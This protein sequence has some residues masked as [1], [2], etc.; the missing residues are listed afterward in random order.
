LVLTLLLSLSLVACFG[1]HGGGGGG[2]NGGGGGGNG[3][4]G[5]G[6][7]G[8]GGGGGGGATVTIVEPTVSG[9]QVVASSTLDFV[10]KVKGGSG[11]GVNWGVQSGDTCTNSNGVSSLGTLGGNNNIGTIPTTTANQAVAVYNAPNASAIPGSGFLTVTVTALQ[12]PSTMGPC[13]VV[14]VLPTTNSLIFGNY[15]FRLKG[16]SNSSGLPF[17]IVGRLH[18]DGVGKPDLS[19]GI[20]AGLEDVNIAQAN[21]SSAAFTKVAFT[22]GYDMDSPSHGTMKLTIAT[23][24]A[25]WAALPNP[26]PTTMN[27]SFTLSLDGFFGGLIETDGSLSPVA[28]V[29]SGDFQ[30]QANSSKFTTANI[31]NFYTMSLAG[32]AGVG[33]SA[34]NKG[35]IGRVQLTATSLSAGT[36]VSGVNSTGD[37]QSGT[38]LQTGPQMLTGTYLIDDQTN[39]HGTLTITATLNAKN[40][41]YTISFYIGFPRFFYALR[42]DDNPSGTPDGILLGT[43]N[44]L[45]ATSPFTNT[46]LGSAQFEMLG[47]TSS[48]HGSAAAGVLVGGAGQNSTTQGLLQG[49]VDFNDG[50]SLPASPPASFISTAPNQSSFTIAPTGRGT[51]S[52]WV[53]TSNGP[54]AF[55]FVFYLN[56]QGGGYLLEQPASDGSNRGRSGSFFP[57]T[58][59]SG[60]IG[61]FVASTEVATAASQNSLAVLPLTVSGK[62]GNFQ[63]GTEDLSKLGSAATLG[64]SVS[65]TF[66]ATDANNRGTATVTTGSL[67]GNGTVA[68]YV[69]SNTEVIVISSDGSNTEPQIILLTNSL[70]VNR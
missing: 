15:V 52:V 53:Q 5:G 59:T 29:G 64:S 69:A 55:N 30:F 56:G 8:G 28:Y 19:S 20:T 46:S 2:G 54:V 50:G 9:A 61:A 62:S 57:Q 14:Y 41:L 36:I 6:N 45:P 48:G 27:F 47:I 11:T 42:I 23:P 34:V 70:P 3:G 58:V 4:G 25:A 43:M 22:G 32:P 63:N 17:G 33:A 49:V 26:P 65:G 31:V 68:F 10:A 21:G 38:A 40:T 44:R 7:G 60:A 37:D 51:M 12:S 18:F 39:G 24:P 66:T 67:A 1:G 16:F 35:F 13:I